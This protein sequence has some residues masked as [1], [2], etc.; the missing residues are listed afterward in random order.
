[1]KKYKGFLIGGCIIAAIGILGYM[2]HANDA[3]RNVGRVDLKK[4]ENLDT[5]GKCI[6]DSYSN[7]GQ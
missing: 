5:Y 3:K 1:M 6:G 7:Y 4:A 2:N